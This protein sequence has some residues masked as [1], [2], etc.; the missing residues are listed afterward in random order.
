MVRAL[1]DP[2]AEVQAHALVQLRHR[3]IPNA[4]PR[5]IEMVD[6]PHAV[7]RDAVRTQLDEFRL[8][9]YLAAF[10]TLD[11]GVRRSTG[12]LILKID[13]EALVLTTCTFGRHDAGLF[14]AML[15]W[16]GIS[17]RYLNVQRCKRM[18]AT[19]ALSGEA[20]FR[21]LADTTMPSRPARP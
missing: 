9:R 5:L 11:E 18:L 3:G 14:D 1:D 19:R 15:E 16:A 20:V 6:S 12:E 10:D 13:P 8:E 21:A 4:M 7:V 2:Y 17:G